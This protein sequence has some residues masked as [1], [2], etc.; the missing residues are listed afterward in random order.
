MNVYIKSFLI[1]A[2]S[3]WLPDIAIQLVLSDNLLWIILLTAVVPTIVITTWYKQYK[4]KTF[5]HYPKAY[6][7]FMLLGIWAT[8]PI[9]IAVSMQF[10][11]GTFFKMELEMFLIM[12]ISFP[13]STFMLSTYSGSL[14]GIIIVSL[15][16]LK[17]SSIASQKYKTSN[18]NEESNNLP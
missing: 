18:K 1:G 10:N 2:G 15:A 16:L 17:V 14:G 4:S 12:W 6:P 3:Y 5:Y 7:L 8:G 11:G 9:A 13:L